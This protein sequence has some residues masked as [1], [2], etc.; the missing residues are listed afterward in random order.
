MI[1]KSLS[2]KGLQQ[3]IRVLNEMSRRPSSAAR[4]KGRQSQNQSGPAAFDPAHCNACSE[5]NKDGARPERAKENLGGGALA[6]GSAHRPETLAPYVLAGLSV[7]AARG[8]R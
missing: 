4:A 5:S 3:F 8:V 2:I 6:P 1:M 7:E